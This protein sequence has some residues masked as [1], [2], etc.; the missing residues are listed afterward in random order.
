MINHGK[1]YCVNCKHCVTTSL[2]MQ[3]CHQERNTYEGP[4]DLV[5]GEPIKVEVPLKVRYPETCDTARGP[6]GRCGPEGRFFERRYFAVVPVYDT[7][8]KGLWRQIAE[9]VWDDP[10]A[11]L[12][13]ILTAVALVFILVTGGTQ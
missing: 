7:N 13:L 6:W 1:R 9:A 10:G 4:R 2:G 3:M 5:T 8:P 11:V 12:L